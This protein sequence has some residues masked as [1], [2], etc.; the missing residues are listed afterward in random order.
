MYKLE[1][2]VIQE[3]MDSHIETLKQEMYEKF[4]DKIC[5]EA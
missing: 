4:H 3:V 2:V 1:D 5:M